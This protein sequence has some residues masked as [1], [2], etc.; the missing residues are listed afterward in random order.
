MYKLTRS[1]LEASL[2]GTTR[3]TTQPAIGILPITM[4]V[5][6][7]RCQLTELQLREF[8]ELAEI[9]LRVCVI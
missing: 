5:A 2:E 3:S 9:V 4:L 6:W 8:A 7:T 1:F